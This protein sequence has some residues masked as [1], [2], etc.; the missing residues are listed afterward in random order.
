MPSQASA[1][2]SEISH[3]FR[4]SKGSREKGERLAGM[5]VERLVGALRDGFGAPP[6]P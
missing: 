3:A 4:A 5:L 1:Q 6:A 2:R